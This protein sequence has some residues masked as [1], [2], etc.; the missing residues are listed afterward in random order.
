[1]NEPWEWT[2]AQEALL[3]SYERAHP[4][5]GAMF[6]E[7]RA[8]L[9]E[10]E[11]LQQR[12]ADSDAVNARYVRRVAELTDSAEDWHRVADAR[13]EELVKLQQENGALRECL[14]ETCGGTGEI[15]GE[16]FG[17]AIGGDCPDCGTAG[18]IKLK[19]RVAE[20]ENEQEGLI[21][22]NTSL[23]AE[24]DEARSEVAEL[25]RE[26]VEVKTARDGW[27]T[28]A[29]MWSRDKQERIDA[30][31]PDAERWRAFCA[32]A[33][34]SDSRQAE[35]DFVSAQGGEDGDPFWEITTCGKALGSG[36]TPGE[37]IDAAKS[38]EASES[39]HAADAEKVEA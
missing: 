8:A 1:M 3:K 37:A 34:E 32:I 16:R 33:I 23:T 10:I 39:Q 35:L 30:L 2:D 17:E 14:C 18:M 31:G 4:D 20:L 29:H 12:C 36:R 9:A 13:A 6:R 15:E 11:R 38:G 7:L 21:S 22:L 19:Q 24:R 28:T 26:V 5:V 25:E 27:L